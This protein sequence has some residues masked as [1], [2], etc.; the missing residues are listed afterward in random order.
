MRNYPE[1]RLITTGLVVLCGL[2]CAS[3]LSPT[4]NRAISIGFGILLGL[5]VLLGIGWWVRKE[6]QLRQEF[7]REPVDRV[8]DRQE[9]PR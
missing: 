2:G 8:H 4:I 5:G 3:S 9:V 1:M 7:D 6:Y